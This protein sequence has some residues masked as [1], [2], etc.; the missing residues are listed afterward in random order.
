MLETI[1]IRYSKRD[2]Y[3]VLMNKGLINL[4]KSEQ[5]LLKTLSLDKD[6]ILML[7][8][9]HIFNKLKYLKKSKRQK[10]MIK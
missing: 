7:E 2:L 4:T 10:G 5:Q 6:I 3:I 1:N 9:D 8:N